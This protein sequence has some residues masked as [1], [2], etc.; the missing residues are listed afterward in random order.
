MAVISYDSRHQRAQIRGL[1]NPLDSAEAAHRQ[2]HHLLCIARDKL[3]SD[4]DEF[5]ALAAG[6]IVGPMTRD[7]ALPTAMVNGNLNGD[8]PLTF[9]EHSPFI[10][11][12]MT[13]MRTMVLHHNSV[14]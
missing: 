8:G 3:A 6:Y 9:V 2:L 4:E 5:Y 7:I 11:V 10:D 13:R 14:L 12:G 1:R